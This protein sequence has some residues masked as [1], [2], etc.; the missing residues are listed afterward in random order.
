MK[1]FLILLLFACAFVLDAQPQT[2]YT[3]PVFP[4]IFSPADIN[5]SAVMMGNVQIAV[6]LRDGV[7]L[8]HDADLYSPTGIVQ[9]Q[10]A[11]QAQDFATA[12]QRDATALPSSLGTIA[13]IIPACDLSGVWNADPVNGPTQF[14]P[15]PA[16]GCKAGYLQPSERLYFTKYVPLAGM[17]NFSLAYASVLSGGTFHLEIAGKKVSPVWAP[18]GTTG[19]W[20][21]YQ[22]VQPGQVQ[23]PGGIVTV[24]VVV[25]TGGFDLLWLGFTK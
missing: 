10:I 7:I 3:P 9:M 13:L 17:Y 5:N 12:L 21:T 2:G 18:L 16:Y 11:K 1:R 20:S 8:K 24:C 15:D 19:A 4:P 23:L 14:S 22:T 25:D 6:A